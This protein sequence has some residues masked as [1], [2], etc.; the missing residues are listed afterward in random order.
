MI[1]TKFHGS[2]NNKFFVTE[3]V[4]NTWENSIAKSLKDAASLEV[5]VYIMK[6]TC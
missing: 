1:S 5:F 3:E 6:E 4:M 2:K